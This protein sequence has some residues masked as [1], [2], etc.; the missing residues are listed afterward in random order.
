MESQDN[1]PKEDYDE[2]WEWSKQSMLLQSHLENMG[3]Q[4]IP[5]HFLPTPKQTCTPQL[6]RTNVAE[7]KENVL[8]IAVNSSP[9]HQSQGTSCQSTCVTVNS[10]EDAGSGSEDDRYEERYEA[11]I[12]HDDSDYEGGEGYTH[13]TDDTNAQIVPGS[14]TANYEEPW[15]L[16]AKMH[17]F[18]E[19]L[20]AAA[21]SVNQTAPVPPHEND[22][23]SQEG[24]E[25]PW[26]W[27]KQKMDDRPQEGYEKPWD[28]SQ[29]RKDDRPM[30]EYEEPWHQKQEQLMAKAGVPMKP[31]K[32]E[33]GKYFFLHFS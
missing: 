15:D 19:K 32:P 9:V 20:K 1:R 14:S 16:S 23:R 3:P 22:Q 28:W 11:T 21:D 18:D 4:Y 5:P 7:G 30:Q 10:G 12:P 13:L 17:E 29:H 6:K 2:P 24:Y 33:T 27:S 8:D 25:K 26:D 31:S